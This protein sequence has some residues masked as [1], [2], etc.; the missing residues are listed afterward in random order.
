MKKINNLFISNY[1][2]S[3]FFGCLRKFCEQGY[4]ETKLKR[5]FFIKASSSKRESSASSESGKAKI[6]V[7]GGQNGG[8]VYVETDDAKVALTAMAPATVE[9]GNENTNNS[10]MLT[11]EDG[12]HV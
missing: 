4:K 1:I 9:A 3:C 12:V 2:V 6:K 11:N 5:I 10:K 8:S 7:N